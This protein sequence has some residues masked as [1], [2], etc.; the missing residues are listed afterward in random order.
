VIGDVDDDGFALD[1]AAFQFLRRRVET[2]A[3]DITDPAGS[4]RWVG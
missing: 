3:T 4:R 2:V 1:A